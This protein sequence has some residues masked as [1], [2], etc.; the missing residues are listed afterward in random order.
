MVGLP[1]DGNDIS[2]Y[3]LSKDDS[4]LLLFDRRDVRGLAIPVALAGRGR[5][6]D[7][8]SSGCEG[9]LDA[10]NSGPVGKETTDSR[11]ED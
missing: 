1:P 6:D 3:S 4:V 2:P 7:G 5:D 8:N 10:S 11:A 9:A